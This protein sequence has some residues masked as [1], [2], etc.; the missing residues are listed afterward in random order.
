M[1][2]AQITSLL[3]ANRGEIAR[4]VIRTARG[5][6]IRTVAVY[7]DADARAPHVYDADLAVGLGGTTSAD[8]Y[9]RADKIIDAARR[10]NV[11]AIH[12]GYGFLSENAEFAEE[13]VAAGI[14]FVGPSPDS[15]RRMGLKDQAKTIAR[16][17]GVPVL[18][19]AEI[20][21]DDSDEWVAAA[22][23]VGYPLLVKAI[24]GGGGKGMRRVEVADDL[25]DAINGAR[26]EATSSFGNPKVFIERYLEKSRHVEVQVFGDQHGGAIHLGE[27]ECSVQ[28]RHQ[29][30]LEEAPSPVVGP[31][32]REHMGA[33]AVAL[34]RR[35]GYLGAGTVEYLL[36]DTTGDF[37]FLE[38]NTRL[39]VEHPV[40]EEVT[41]LDLVAMQLRV[42]RGLPLGLSQ[43]EVR[44]S[45]HAIEVRLYAEDPARDFLPTPGRL[46]LLEFPDTPGLRVENGVAPSGEVSA[47]YDPMIAKIIVHAENR[48]ESAIALAAALDATRIHGI[49]TNRDFL[50]A[51]LRNRDFLSGETTTDFLDRHAEL[52]DPP[53]S[54]PQVVHVAAAVSVS[55][56]IRRRNDTVTGFASPGFRDIAAPLTTSAV[57]EAIGND[58]VVVDY[59]LSS[60]A[61]DADLFLRVD[62][63][64]HTVQLVDLTESAVRVRFEGVDHPCA[65]TT[66][67]DGS[68]WVDSPA[69]SSGWRPRP[70]LPETTSLAASA[71]GPISE[72]PG[73]VVDVLVS[74]GDT[75]EAGQKLVVLEAMKMEH[76]ALAGVGGVVESVNVAV[77]QYVEAQVELV[78][79]CEGG[80]S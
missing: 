49:V 68:V 70:R 51:V 7:S 43:S 28:R 77:G 67:D 1:N 73:T 53:R 47:H 32:L 56:A 59:T 42:A 18:P 34:V 72:I 22:Q 40:T 62:G 21:G 27:R 71:A 69:S 5:M 37:Y 12:P 74:A 31:E 23:S 66:H 61:G 8:S 14:I 46:H 20:T 35:L 36:D 58:P 54:T 26:R 50:S 17:A 52:F 2:T 29:K 57:W 45:G 75:V 25:V 11:D 9:L 39:Q 55:V 16:E 30:V 38:M 76:A 33:T 4:R 41:G 63:V 44:R 24:A 10:T 78:T 13:C 48:E 79:I 80:P 6:G 3:V 60:G 64:E 19:D 15:I 65:V